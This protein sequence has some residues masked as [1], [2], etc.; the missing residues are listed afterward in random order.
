[1]IK[2]L[3]ILIFLFFIIDLSCAD[4]TG[5]AEINSTPSTAEMGDSVHLYIN[6]KSNTNISNVE[7]LELTFSSNKIYGEIKYDGFLKIIDFS[8]I[9]DDIN[10]TNLVIQT[11]PEG[12]YKDGS[13]SVPL[14]SNEKIE[15]KIT[16][17]N[18]TIFDDNGDRVNFLNLPT[19]YYIN[20]TQPRSL[21]AGLPNNTLEGQK[22]LKLMEAFKTLDKSEIYKGDS[23]NTLFLLKNNYYKDIEI[24]S[25]DDSLNKNN[26]AIKT[27][28]KYT[29]SQTSKNVISNSISCFSFNKINISSNVK[30]LPSSI[31]YRVKD[32]S[33]DLYSIWTEPMFIEINALNRPP[34]IEYLNATIIEGT[35]F[36]FQANFFDEDGSIDEC[37]LRSNRDP[38]LNST[39]I[40]KKSYNYSSY[41][42]FSSSYGERVITLRVKDNDGA[43]TEKET[44]INVEEPYIKRV[45]VF[46]FNSTIIIFLLSLTLVLIQ[47]ILNRKKIIEWMRRRKYTKSVTRIWYKYALRRIISGKNY[48]NFQKTTHEWLNPLAYLLEIAIVIA[49]ILY[50]SYRFIELYNLF[51]KLISY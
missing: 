41:N 31:T 37:E 50:L 2:I 13:I 7:N 51:L 35:K 45:Y 11:S 49:V 10:G 26:K 38:I 12:I 24:V 36:C 18:V 25:I 9:Y 3:K 28:E 23:V 44:V 16:L 14:M 6:L 27:E 43:W 34:K 46:F 48:W 8:D 29:I 15:L 19:S 30:I 17:K 40:Y 5:N 20:W 22:P 47:L 33:G 42:D 1:M 21:E 32:G 39:K 4:P